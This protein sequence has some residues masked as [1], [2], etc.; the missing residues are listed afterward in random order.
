M[1]FFA[2][3]SIWFWVIT[4]VSLSSLCFF[5]EVHESGMWAAVSFISYFL[6]GYWLWDMHPLKAA[7]DNP[8]TTF[9]VLLSYL[10]V[11]IIWSGV[12]WFNLLKRERKK[13]D[14]KKTIMIKD[15]GRPWDELREDHDLLYKY[16]NCRCVKDIIPS[17]DNNKGNI[18]RWMAYWPVSLFWA[19]VHDLLHDIFEFIYNLVANTYQKMANKIF[20]DL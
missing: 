7:Y 8:N 15:Q 12:K 4:L 17:A 13:F 10:I 20:A 18:V 14:I 1:E 19:V 5:V 6:L 3:V 9:F 16:F 2:A 11:G